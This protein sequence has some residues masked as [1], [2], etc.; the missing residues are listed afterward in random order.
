MA[1]I[2]IIFM[3]VTVLSVVGL[4]L[5]TSGHKRVLGIFLVWGII[6]GILAYNGFFEQTQSMPPR[7]MLI[8]IPVFI[9]VFYC[10]SITTSESLRLGWLLAIHLLRI[11]VEIILARLYAEGLIPKLMTFHGW[12]FDI[13]SGISAVVILALYLSDHL[14]RTL[15]L[16]WNWAALALL[17]VIVISAILSA[18]T[19]IQQLAFDQPNVAV[20]QFPFT[21]LPAIVVPIVLLSH[22]YIFRFTKQTLKK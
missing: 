17:A 3:I 19:P 8:V 21:W 16:I 2:S 22:L 10:A 6:T 1:S 4:A 5:A 13:A 20:L 18:P 11:P 9:I 14:N 7:F 12:N 15:L